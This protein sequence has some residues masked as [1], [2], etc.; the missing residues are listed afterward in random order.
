MPIN[1]TPKMKQKIP[2]KI[3]IIKTECKRNRKSKPTYKKQISIIIKNFKVVWMWLL[4]G[5]VRGSCGEG[6]I[7]NLDWVGGYV[8][9]HM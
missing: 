2:R 9:P 6:G 1:Q 5:S 7:L 8:N 3:Q 4:S